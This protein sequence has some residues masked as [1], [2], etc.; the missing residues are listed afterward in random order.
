MFFLF[1]SGLAFANVAK[2][3]EFSLNRF[4]A[5]RALR[6]LPAYVF[7]SILSIL[8]APY[9]YKPGYYDKAGMDYIQ[10]LFDGSALYHLYFVALIWY[11]YLLFPL[12][13]RLKYTHGR[14]LSMIALGLLGHTI[15]TIFNADRPPVAF[16]FLL[17][18]L[19][20]L[21][22]SPTLLM[23]LEYFAFA[24]PFFQAGIWAGQN[25]ESFRT[26]A[27]HTRKYLPVFIT[28]TGLVF[29]FVLSDFFTRLESGQS[30]D[31]AGRI[32]R[33][34]VV[35]YAVSLI[36]VFTILPSRQSPDWLRKLS[37]CSFLVYLFHP[38]LIFATS[39]IPTLYQIPLV[40]TLSWITA[41][42][43]QEAANR[44]KIFAFLLGEGSRESKPLS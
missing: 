41:S 32:W 13:Y 7:V 10:C 37:R 24:V 28:L 5:S 1:L 14:L 35:I 38:F 36:A 34:S 29:Y 43:L 33:I 44:S 31:E 17:P 39:R 16:S 26:F 18:D 8:I 15:T 11:C 21:F 6:I 20:W 25:M 12:L 27:D 4:F 42:L 40:I 2:R 9:Y 23:W 19:S 22:T 30:A 3:P